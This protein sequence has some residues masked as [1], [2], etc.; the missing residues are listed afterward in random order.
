MSID[1]G[2]NISVRPSING[3]AQSALAGYTVPDR[4]GVERFLEI[5]SY[6]SALLV[7][8]RASIAERFPNNSLTLELE[9]DSDGDAQDKQLVL[10]IET[11]LSPNAALANLKRLDNDWWLDNVA[12]AHGR[13]TINIEFR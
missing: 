2:Q 7:E 4:E 9:P 12:Q 13:L 3:V 11:A 5:H 1:V 6:L 10:L 8:A